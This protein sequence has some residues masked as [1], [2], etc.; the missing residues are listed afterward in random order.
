[1]EQIGAAA[2]KTLIETVVETGA[3]QRHADQRVSG[4]S[5]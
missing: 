4:D 1:L 2:T 3:A 5:R